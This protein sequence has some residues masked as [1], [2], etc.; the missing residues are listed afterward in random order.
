MLENDDQEMPEGESKSGSSCCCGSSADS[1]VDES[2]KEDVT[3]E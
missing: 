3:G 1:Q 2:V